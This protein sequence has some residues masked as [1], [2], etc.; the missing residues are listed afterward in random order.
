MDKGAGV[1]ESEL[2]NFFRPSAASK[3]HRVSVAAEPGLDWVSLAIS[4]AYMAAM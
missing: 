1:P 3:N 4:L 2:E